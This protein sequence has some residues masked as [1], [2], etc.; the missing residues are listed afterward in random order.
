MLDDII[1]RPEWNDLVSLIRKRPGCVV[2]L[3]GSTDTGKSTLCR[4]LVRQLSCSSGAAYLDLDPGQ[5]TI[6]PPATAGLALF[7]GR[8]PSPYATML[9]F[10]GSPSLSGHFIQ[11]MAAAA[12]LLRL[13]RTGK[14]PFVIADSP[15]WVGDLAADEFHV[16]MIDLL[17]PDLVIALCTGNG[18]EPILTCFP[19]PPYLVRRIPPSPDVRPR[20]RRWR[21]WYREEK[22]RTFFAGSVLQEMDLDGIGFHG[23]IP[24]TFLSGDWRGRLVAL[25]DSAMLVVSLAIVDELDVTRSRIRFLAPEK[26]L[27]GVVSIQAGSL[28]FG[29]EFVSGLAGEPGNPV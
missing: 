13:A 5:S 27:D 24:A 8:N 4:Y 10:V 7:D 26:C 29:P 11:E 23:R 2:Y 9:R 14:A 21:A 1:A 15:G 12:H 28:R 25:C 18:L 20:S 22:F 3:L 16:R 19:S 6:G 17:A